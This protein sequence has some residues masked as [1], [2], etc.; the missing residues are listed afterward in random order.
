MSSLTRSSVFQDMSY[1]VSDRRHHANRGVVP[2]S[3]AVVDHRKSK[4]SK[5][6]LKNGRRDAKTE[7]PWLGRARAKISSSP[8][9]PM[10]APGL[11]TASLCL[12]SWNRS[13]LLESLACR[14]VIAP[15]MVTYTSLSELQLF[16]LVQ[17]ACAVHCSNLVF[18][19]R[20]F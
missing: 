10:S 6:P 16:V 19:G 20:K 11:V 5:L 13:S 18:L 9:S 3:R 2:A 15:R 8:L 7:N 17:F 14:S 4:G 1:L 12:L